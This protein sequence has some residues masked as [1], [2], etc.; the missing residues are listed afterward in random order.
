MCQRR[1]AHLHGPSGDQGRRPQRDVNI[2]ALPVVGQQAHFA[3]QGG[4]WLRHHHWLLHQAA[5]LE[6]AS[7]GGTAEGVQTEGKFSVCR[8]GQQGNEGRG[9][10]C[11]WVH[12]SNSRFGTKERRAHQCVMGS[13]GAVDS[14]RCVWLPS[15]STSNQEA[16]PCTAGG[17]A[18][19]W[20]RFSTRAQR[21]WWNSAT[22]NPT[23]PH[24][25]PR[26]PRHQQSL[27]QT[28]A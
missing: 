1:G 26:K 12:A 19:A 2:V 15:K 8:R 24:P 20:G 27:T 6:P 14:Q 22:P 10:L 17:W 3:A 16:T 11:G 18:G 4:P 13:P 21:G 9:L 23:P 7:E 5:Q 28:K 25:T